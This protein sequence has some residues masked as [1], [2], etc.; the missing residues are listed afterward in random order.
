QALFHL[1]EAR[2]LVAAR[3]HLAVIDEEPR[4]IER[5]RHPGDHCQNVKR[6]EV[7]VIRRQDFRHAALRSSSHC[8]HVTGQLRLPPAGLTPSTATA[9]FTS[10][11][12]PAMN[13]ACVPT[14]GTRT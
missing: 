4:Q 10:L 9:S 14:A 7:R 8:P 5:P 6:L 3:L 12:S 2:V 1:H 11:A 13:F